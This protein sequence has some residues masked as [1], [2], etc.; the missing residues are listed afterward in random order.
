MPIFFCQQ[1]RRSLNLNTAYLFQSITSPF[2]VEGIIFLFSW[3]GLHC[4]VTETVSSAFSKAYLPRLRWQRWLSRS[5]VLGAHVTVQYH[6]QQTCFTMSDVCSFLYIKR[7]GH[8]FELW[9]S[10]SWFRD[11]A[12][13]QTPR[14][15]CALNL[16]VLVCRCPPANRPNLAEIYLI[17]RD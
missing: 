9:F 3:D 12:F 11:T 4:L 16:Y 1:L 7:D 10:H 2:R 15:P 8:S 5:P 6:W 14:T 13:L 17:A